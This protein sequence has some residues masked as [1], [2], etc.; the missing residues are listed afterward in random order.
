MSALLHA[1]EQVRCQDPDGLLRPE[2]VVQAAADPASPLHSSFTWDDT[3]AAR[4]YRLDQARAL[5]R[6]A[7]TILPHHAEPVRAYVSLTSD[8]SSRPERNERGEE[9]EAGGYRPL[10]AVLQ[11]DEQRRLLLEDA[12][13]DLRTLQ[14]KYAQLSE[15]ASVFEAAREAQAK[16]GQTR[17]PKKKAKA[18]A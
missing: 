17:A 12:L 2:A 4:R 15:L 7:V 5:I 11:D 16:A 8:R 18:S 3:E 14:R 1:L 13:A 6:V 10:P 9:R